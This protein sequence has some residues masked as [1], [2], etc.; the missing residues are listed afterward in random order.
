MN[1]IVTL[2]SLVDYFTGPALIFLFL[3]IF[4]EVNARTNP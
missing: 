1:L 3:L 2:Q 4:V